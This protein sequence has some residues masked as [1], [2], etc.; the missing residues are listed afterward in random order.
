MD[1]YG[2]FILKACPAVLIPGFIWWDKTKKSL[3]YVW[4]FLMENETQKEQW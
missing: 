1:T 4:I 2:L 3:A